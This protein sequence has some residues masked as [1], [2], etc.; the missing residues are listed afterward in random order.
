MNHRIGSIV[1]GVI[2]GL[3]VAFGAYRWITGTDRVDERRTEERMVE[4]S[5]TRIEQTLQ[6][7]A[8]QFVDPLAPR[9]P[10]GKTY[11]YPREEGGWQVSGYYRRDDGDRWHPYLITLAADGSLVHLKVQDDDAALSGRAA[12]DARLEVLR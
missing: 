8:L 5:R 12:A 9:R 7:E 2:V 10:V 4:Y 3:A 6:I 11:V 1:F